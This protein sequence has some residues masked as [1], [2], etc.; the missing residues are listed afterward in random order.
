MAALRQ[1]R[2]S[3]EALLKE[4]KT[5]ETWEFL[6]AAL[7]AVLVKT[8]E[9]ELLV[10]KLRRVYRNSKSERL[11]PAQLALLFE[12]LV[13]KGGEQAAVD[14][15]AEAKED[16]Q[17][18][19]EIEDA[20]RGGPNAEKK[21]RKK[22]PGYVT[23]GVERRSHKAKVP[24]AE[25]TCEQCGRKMNSIGEDLTRRLEYVPGHFIEHEHW[26]EKLAC[27]VCKEGVTTAPAPPQVLNRSAA[28]ASLLA[29]VVVSK[30]ADH[31]PLHR[32]SRIYAR[33]GADIPVST[34]ADWTAGVGE[35]IEPLVDRLYLRVL[36]AYI[37]GTDATGLMVL[38]PAS[39]EHIQRGSIWVLT[40]DKR[41]VVFRYTQT[42]DGESGPWKFLAGRT[43]YIQ[44][45]AASVFDRLFNGKVASAIELGCWSHARRKL[46][47]LQDTDFR[48]AYPLKLIARL[49]RVEH[50]ADARQLEPEERAELR[51][52]RSAPTL[53]KLKRRFVATSAAEPPSSELAQATA[54]ALNH[55]TALTRFIE[56]GR[57]SL[58]NNHVEQQLRDVALGRKNYLFAGSHDA[59]RRAANIYSLTRT[60]AQYRVPP[61]PYFTDVLRKLGAGWDG[62]QLDE[63][64][65]HRWQ[66]PEPQASPEKPQGP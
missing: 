64:L 18:D 38:D 46:V 25:K 28:D 2:E 14:P 56:D 27:G 5:D 59:A 6:L 13:S 57:V 1:V 54:Y 36:K 24:E 51:Q 39:P 43:G 26:L 23:Q 41:D 49:Y 17:L 20:E 9:L 16:A 19:R 33:S 40:G 52:E 60:C 11:D 35:L 50:L 45:D 66:A 22:G 65:P 29:H 53:E 62:D 42:G 63:L 8:Q 55:W 61:L 4:G 37:I 31:T 7:E 12:E 21:R 34:L 44:A 32:L 10:A 30:A 15:E 48:V 3:A 47:A 58:D